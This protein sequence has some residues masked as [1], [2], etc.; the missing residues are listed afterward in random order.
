MVLFPFM[1]IA[2]GRPYAE[3]GPI[4]VHAEPCQRYAATDEYPQDFQE[5]RVIRAYNSNHEIIAAEVPDR[6]GPEAVIARFLEK[7]ETAF[8]HVRSLTRGCYT[9]EIQRQ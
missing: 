9:M 7:P 3:S 1:A 5:G 2:S 8:V 4:F 6:A